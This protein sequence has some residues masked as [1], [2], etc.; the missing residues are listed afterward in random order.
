MNVFPETSF[1]LYIRYLRFYFYKKKCFWE[2]ET[3]G[4]KQRSQIRLLLSMPEGEPY[5]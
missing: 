4:F 1:V 2:Q 5:I 3:K